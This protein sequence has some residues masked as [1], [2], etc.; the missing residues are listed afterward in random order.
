MD[1]KQNYTDA[2]VKD[3]QTMSG[4]PLNWREDLWR[5][6][7]SAIAA[8]GVASSISP[9]CVIYCLSLSLPVLSSIYHKLAINIFLHPLEGL[10][11]KVPEIGLFIFMGFLSA[12]KTHSLHQ[13]AQNIPH[14]LKT[15]ST[16]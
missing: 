6:H 11:E 14:K 9:A 5:T 1:L 15:T 7:F 12:L 2:Y 10:H 8:R 13:T 4:F 3:K 16:D